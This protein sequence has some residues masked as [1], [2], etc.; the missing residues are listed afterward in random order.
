MMTLDSPVFTIFTATFN[1]AGTLTRVYE[2]LCSQTYR[3]FEWLIIDDGSTDATGEMVSRWRGEATFSIRY[4]WQEN[5]GKH[6]AH[7]VAL[8]KAQ[9]EF[10][11]V[12]DSDDSIVP[13]ALSVCCPCGILFP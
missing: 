7:N 12:L 13:D 1:R 8:E 10:F 9:G 4:Y 5:R 11:I 3:D 6:V 2:G